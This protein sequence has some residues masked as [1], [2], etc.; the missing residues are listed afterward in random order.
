M[1]GINLQE[2]LNSSEISEDEWSRSKCDW[3]NLEEIAEDFEKN[4]AAL[5]SAAELISSRIR[6]FPKVHSVRWRIKDT[7]HLLKKIVRKNL[8]K[9][10]KEKWKNINKGNYLQTVTDLI[11][12]R[13]LHLFVDEC[14]AID[15]SIRE[16][17]SLSEQVVIYIREGDRILQ[18]IIDQGGHSEIHNDGYRSIHYIIETK[19]EKLTLSA[20]IQ[21]RTI[22]QEGWSEI[23]HKIR[24][25]DFSDNEHIGIFLKLFAGLAGS[26]DEMGS[27]VKDLSHVLKNIDHEKKS[28]IAER[29][30]AFKERDKALADM[31]KNLQEFEKLKQEDNASKQLIQKLRKDIKILQNSSDGLSGV[32]PSRFRSHLKTVPQTLSTGPALYGLEA[33]L[34]ATNTQPVTQQTI[35]KPKKANE[36]T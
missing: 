34:R 18:D 13:A 33:F 17:W 2:F 8:E 19:P 23:D 24:Y 5:I 36:D 4:K 32:T 16:T 25:P 31:E 7:E 26:A 3:K 10:P 21:V 30:I 35:Q 22:F 9:E 15:C 20:E 11:G 28:M 29:E 27:F 1:T 14:F 6:N 12:V